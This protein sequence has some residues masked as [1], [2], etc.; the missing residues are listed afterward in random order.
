MSRESSRAWDQEGC[1]ASSE[2]LGCPG[3][4]RMGRRVCAWSAR[5]PTKNGA[6]QIAPHLNSTPGIRNWASTSRSSGRSGARG[7]GL[8][9]N[10]LAETWVH[11]ERVAFK[12]FSFI[13]G[14]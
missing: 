9:G 13:L 11:A 6:N 2:V 10:L 14:A 5:W 12:D 8:T 7:I 1:E 4:G 3:S